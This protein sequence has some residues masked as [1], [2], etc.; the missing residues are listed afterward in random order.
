MRYENSH[1]EGDRRGHRDV[2][3]PTAYDPP[4]TNRDL[5]TG[6]GRQGGGERTRDTA[7]ESGT[8]RG[9]QRQATEADGWGVGTKSSWTMIH[10]GR[11]CGDRVRGS[12]E[13]T[14]KATDG[15]EVG[16]GGTNDP[17]ND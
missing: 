11:G 4:G 8:R 10:T 15:G 6:R 3:V 2:E 12:G 7:A 5:G 16:G 1:G 17:E 13:A 9:A 14:L